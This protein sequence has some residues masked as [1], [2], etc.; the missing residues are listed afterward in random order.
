MATQQWYS[1]LHS[2]FLPFGKWHSSLRFFNLTT[3]L[4]LVNRH[5]GPFSLFTCLL[6]SSR[7]KESEQSGQKQDPLSLRLSERRNTA[8]PP[9]KEER[10]GI[11]LCLVFVI[12]IKCGLH[13]D[14]RIPHWSL[15]IVMSTHFEFSWLRHLKLCNLRPFI[16]FGPHIPSLVKYKS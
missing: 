16:F 2:S 10:L 11:A 12:S 15:K 14:G 8:H 6:V 5:S 7:G 1:E 4:R 9:G 3:Q 13:T